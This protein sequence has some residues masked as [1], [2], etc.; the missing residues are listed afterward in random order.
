VAKLGVERFVTFAGFVPDEELPGCYAAADL[1]V[2]VSRERPQR[3][4][5][6]GFGIVYLEASAAGRPVVAGRSGG[7]SDAVEDGVSGLLVDPEDAGAVGE[8]VSQLLRDPGLRARM[9]RAGRQRVRDRFS[10]QRGSGAFMEMLDELAGG[11]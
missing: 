10:V 5:V 1:F 2:M 11:C 4:D 8:A 9:A 6:E 7:V 3:G